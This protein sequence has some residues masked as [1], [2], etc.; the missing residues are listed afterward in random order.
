MQ[1]E[2]LISPPEERQG[3]ALLSL[4]LP[5]SNGPFPRQGCNTIRNKGKKEKAGK[6][7]IFVPA[8]VE[9]PVSHRPMREKKN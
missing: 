7:N 9:K 6:K 1:N 5:S 4:P 2:I 8:R 3:G